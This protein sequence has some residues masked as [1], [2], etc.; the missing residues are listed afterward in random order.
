VKF[1]TDGVRGRANVDLTAAH[2]L[3]L[4]RAIA[5]VL[6]GIPIV[7]G[8]DTRRSTPMLEGALVA[9]LSSQG[10]DVIRLGVAP[11]PMV[12][13]TAAQLG[14]GGAVISASH[15]PFFD[16]G[17]KV[18]GPGGRKLSDEVEAEI[19][20]RY[21]DPGPLADQPGAVVERPA[22][23]VRYL[24]HLTATLSTTSL[25]G[26]RLVVDCSNGAASPLVAE[27]FGRLGA[28]LVLINAEPDGM[29]INADCGATDPSGLAEAVMSHGAALGLAFDGDADRLIA[30]DERGEVVDGDRLLA[31]FALDLKSRSALRND[32]VVVTVMTNLGFHRAMDAAGIAVIQTAV[33]D[34]AVLEVLDQRSLS[35][36]GEQSGHII[37]RD[38]ATTGDGMLSG[39]MLIDAIRRD[40]RPLSEIARTS[41]ERLPQVLRNL[42]IDDRQLDPGALRAIID[43]VGGRAAD[44]LGGDGRVMIRPSGTEPLVRVMVEASTD[45]Q[46]HAVASAVIDE[47]D[48]EIAQS[49]PIDGGTTHDPPIGNI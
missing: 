13:F 29:N 8:G 14:C 40:G 35:L 45:E 4:G 18:F 34:R 2:A 12:A 16:N 24:D 3:A 43:R 10:A 32:T 19:E 7:V 1:G 17:I 44:R 25:D 42:P 38:H 15:N 33:G 37:L 5:S 41:M 49:G 48:H 6:D 36:G 22:E 39:L 47:I 28:D 23:R 31:I 9:G 27:L 30:V 20:Q 46:A 21:A 11:T 26:Y